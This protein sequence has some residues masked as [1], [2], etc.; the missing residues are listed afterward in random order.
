VVP[1][2]ILGAEG[3]ARLFDEPAR[4]LFH[5]RRYLVQPNVEGIAGLETPLRH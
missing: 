2:R 1:A 3:L 4:P 5:F